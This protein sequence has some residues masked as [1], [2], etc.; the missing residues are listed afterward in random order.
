MVFLF[1]LVLFF[2]DLSFLVSLIFLFVLCGKLW[3][4]TC[5]S[6]STE[7]W[8]IWWKRECIWHCKSCRDVLLLPVPVENLPQF[9]L[10]LHGVLKKEMCSFSFMFS[11]L[12]FLLFW[13]RFHPVVFC[14]LS[15]LSFCQRTLCG[16][17]STSTVHVCFCWI[18]AAWQLKVQKKWIHLR[19]EMFFLV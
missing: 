12:F 4:R 16:A 8:T 19:L 5:I 11:D 14:G 3:I 17:L 1:F 2:D 6:A 18:F 7:W 9:P 13:F 15:A 10:A